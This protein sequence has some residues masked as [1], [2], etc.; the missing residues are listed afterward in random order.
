MKHTIYIVIRLLFLV[1]TPSCGQTALSV[2][3]SKNEKVTHATAFKFSI[4]SLTDTTFVFDNIDN[5]ELQRKTR[6][7]SIK[8][9]SLTAVFEYTNDGVTWNEVEYDFK[10]DTNNLKR[11]EISLHFAANANHTEFLQDFTVDFF[12]T[13]NSVSL[14]SG[15]LKIGSCPVFS[16]TNNSDTTFWGAS[17]SN[18]FYGTIETKTAVGWSPFFSGSYC[19]STVPEK[20]LTK[21]DTLYSWIPSYS[22]GEEYKITQSGTFNYVVQ[23][24]LEQFS[25]GTPTYLISNGQ[26]RKRTRI[27]YEVEKEFT[28]H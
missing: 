13:T 23:M 14:Q 28:V 16:L 5:L 1:L 15:E 8:S 10:V 22:P 6:P 26:T 3:Y 17:P 19:T 24:G 11:I 25:D 7:L 12:Y 20:P 27:F 9:D 2:K 4:L 21:G 18:H